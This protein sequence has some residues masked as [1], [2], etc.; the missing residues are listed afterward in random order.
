MYFGKSVNMD[1]VKCFIGKQVDVNTGAS[2][3]RDSEESNY[4][5]FEGLEVMKDMAFVNE[6]FGKYPVIKVNFHGPVRKLTEVD[7]DNSCKSVIHKAYREQKY[8][9][10]SEHLDDDEIDVCRKWCHE[11]KYKDFSSTDSCNALEELSEYL[12]KHHNEKAF[13]LVD[14]YDSLLI[15]AKFG[16]SEEDLDNITSLP[17][18]IL[19]PA[20][21]YDEHVAGEILTGTSYITGMGL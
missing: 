21:R 19:V 4:K 8:L 20:L 5:L 10:I 2:V 1:M 6:F 7:A 13:M 11:K 3:P 16:A 18:G 14:E 15:R 17:V 9:T 12:H